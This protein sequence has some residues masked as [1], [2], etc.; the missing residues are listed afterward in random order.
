M[1]KMDIE[2]EDYSNRNHSSDLQ[3]HVKSRLAPLLDLDVPS[4]LSVELPLRVKNTEKAIAM[5]GGSEKLK[6]CFIEPDM[7]LELRLRGEDP[8]SHPIHSTVLKNSKNVLMKFRIPKRI[9]NA[10]NRDIRKSIEQCENEGIKYFVEPYGILK[11]NYKFRE[12]ADF[13]KITKESSFNKEFSDSIRIGDYEK[14]QGFA[15]KLQDQMEQVQTFGDG[16]LDLPPIIRYARS[17]VS[18]NYKYFGNLLIDEHGEWL[19]KA[20]KLYTIHI[21][22]EDK[23]PTDH[24][25]RLDGEY[26]KAVED[27]QNMRSSNIPERIINESPSFHLIECLKI[28]KKLFE[29]KPIWIRRHIHWLLPKQLRSQLRFALPFV[30]YTFAKGP[31]RHSF[32]KFGYDPRK[33][34]E[35]YIYQIEAFRGNSRVNQDG[36][37]EKLIENEGNKYIIPP[38][39]YKYI[40]EFSNEESDI[41]KLKI[42]KIPRQLFFDGKN[43]CNSLAFQ[44]GDIMDEDVKKILE[45]TKF[46]SVCSIETGWI[47]L[48]TL[49]KVKSVMKYKLMCIREGM[50]IS[51]EKVHE[52]MTRTVFKAEGEMGEDDEEENG[53]NDNEDGDEIDHDDDNDEDAMAGTSDGEDRGGADKEAAALAGAEAPTHGGDGQGQEGDMDIFKRLEVLNPKSVAVI[54]D[55]ENIIK[56]ESL[57]GEHL[58]KPGSI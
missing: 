26:N 1:D 51:E 58:V 19:N 27:I 5:I 7:K 45:N 28:I 6:K 20:V 17:N 37:I 36:E 8:L 35:S 50:S 34:Q 32:I 4:L 30:S 57:M 11:Q 10:N 40:D 54:R 39:L 55:L 14:I 2:K 41:N 29:L 38:T 9:L 22:W 3:H 25:P 18:H 16:D 43:P 23:I 15:Q 46:E 53:D 49:S 48:V 31:W 12:L 47:D 44:I 24:D 42:G 52:L 33:H 21:Q 13:Q 56:Q